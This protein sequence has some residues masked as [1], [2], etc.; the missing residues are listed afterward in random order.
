ME[1]KQA[2]LFKV[3]GVE[4]R[5]RIID[6]AKGATRGKQDVGV[7]GYHSLCRFT[8]SES[9]QACGVGSE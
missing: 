4:S 1:S 2:E 9:S 3:L 5:I 6:L 8:T 7:I